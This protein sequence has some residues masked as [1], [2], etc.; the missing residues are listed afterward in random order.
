MSEEEEMLVMLTSELAGM[1]GSFAAFLSIDWIGRKR[2]LAF[3]FITKTVVFYLLVQPAFRGAIP[4][5]WI[6]GWIADNVLWAVLPITICELFPTDLRGL[7][8]GF[9]CSWGRIASVILPFFAGLLLSTPGA[10]VNTAINLL[11]I[12]NILGLLLVVA[13]PRETAQQGIAD[14]VGS[15]AK[16][17]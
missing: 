16:S 12:G 14:S 5:I 6:I 2:L 10:S 8:S 4:T 13:I 15:P 11:Q 9:T 1:F 3:G 17:S 7:G